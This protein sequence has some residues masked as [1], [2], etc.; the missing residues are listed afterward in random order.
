MCIPRPALIFD[1]SG[2]LTLSSYSVCAYSG[3]LHHRFKC[4]AALCS[5]NLTARVAPNLLPFQLPP[6]LPPPLS[7]CVFSMSNIYE[8]A[9]ATLGFISSPCLTKVEL[10]VACR[11]ISDRDA[12]SKPDPCVVLKMQ[13]H[14]Q[15]FEVRWPPLS[16]IT[17]THSPRHYCTDRAS[18]TVRGTIL[19]SVFYLL[20]W[21][22]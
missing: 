9:E 4:A 15:W 14:G 2:V 1:G 16:S 12:L 22:F 13:S 8:S 3:P 21:Y 17:D 7:K 11:G 10:R 6:H 20:T 19:R 18:V 5:V